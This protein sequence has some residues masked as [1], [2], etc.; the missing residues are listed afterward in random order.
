MTK[1]STGLILS[2]QKSI[3][4]NYGHTI[5]SVGYLNPVGATGLVSKTYVYNRD[6]ELVQVIDEI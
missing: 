5:K 2:R 4:D 6:F 1:S 3:Y